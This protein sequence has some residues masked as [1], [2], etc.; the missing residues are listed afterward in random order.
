MAFT[1]T[2]SSKGGAKLQAVLKKAEDARRKKVKVG[3]FASAK[4]EGRS[5][6]FVLA[7]NE[8]QVIGVH[9][10]ARPANV[11]EGAQVANVAA[12]LE[13][14]APKASIP[15]RPFFRQS[16]AI[17]EDG[18]PH[19]LSGIIDPLTMEVGDRE[20]N[21]VGAWAADIIQDRIVELK[22]PPNSELTIEL[23][24]SSNPLIDEG[25]MQSSRNLGGGIDDPKGRQSVATHCDSRHTE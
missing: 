14:G 10:P 15:E 11:G 20:A 22:D 3:F 12:I 8:G 17:M 9:G 16:I 13:F 2:V 7:R 5:N 1:T 24:G 19:F 23:K 6:P 25:F 21:E 4:Y 18:L